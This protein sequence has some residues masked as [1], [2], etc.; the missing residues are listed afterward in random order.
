LINQTLDVL[1]GL[2]DNIKGLFKSDK[3]SSMTGDELQNNRDEILQKWGDDIRK[4][5][6]NREKDYEEF[7]RDA[8]RRGRSSFGKN[9]NPESPKNRE[10]SLYVDYLNNA[11]KYF[12]FERE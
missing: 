10:E 2:R 3:A 4:T 8:L 1:T 5:G 11:A 12:R 7:Y 6:K 9:F